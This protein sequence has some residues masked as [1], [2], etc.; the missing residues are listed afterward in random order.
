MQERL[1][2]LIAQA[3]I[4]SRREA[5]T[6]ITQGRVTINGRVATLG[7]KADPA[8]DDIRVDGSRLRLETERVYLMLNKPMGVVTTVRAQ[9][10]ETR[11]TVRDMVPIKG[12]LYP[13]GRLDAD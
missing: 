6:M 4:A 11:R 5:E 3:G 1:Q 9:E 13:V 2:K 8:T 12:H 7:E 10:Q